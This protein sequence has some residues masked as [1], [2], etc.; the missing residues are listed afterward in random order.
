[1]DPKKIKSRRDLQDLIL[2]L[3]E[4]KVQQEYTIGDHW[5]AVK[6]NYKPKN[7]IRNGIGNLISEG[8]SNPGLVVSAIGLGLGILLR[9]LIIGKS[10]NMA[11]KL[12]GTAVQFGLSGLLAKKS[13]GDATLNFLKK[14]FAKKKQKRE[15]KLLVG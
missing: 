15:P 5:E 3:E 13:S 4:A 10:H 7:L 2:V 8:K 6:E 12:A 9:R 11:R 1:M 14:I